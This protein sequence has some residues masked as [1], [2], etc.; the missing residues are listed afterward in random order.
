MAEKR[1]RI[2]MISMFRNEARVMRRM[3][4]SC[5]PHIDY[6]VLQ[7]NGSTDGTDEIVREFFRENPIPGHLYVVEEGWKGFGWNRDHLIQT[8]QGL[9]HGCDWILKMDCDECLEV[10]PDF[11]WSVLDDISTQAWNVVSVGGG[12]M[13]YRMWLWNARLPWR[14]NHDPCHETIRCELSDIDH[15][16]RARDLPLGFRHRGYNEGQSWS[17]PCKFVTDSLILEE[18]LIREGQLPSNMYHFFYLAKSYFDAFRSESLALGMPHQ[19]EYARRAIFYFTEW[20]NRQI[21][22]GR[23]RIDEMVYMAMMMM[24]ESFE[25]FE[26]YDMALDIYRR[27][28][29]FAPGRNDH[30]MGQAEIFKKRRQW[31]EML[32]ITTEMMKPERVNPFPCYAMFINQYMYHDVPDNRVIPLHQTAVE[33]A[34]TGIQHRFDYRRTQSQSTQPVIQPARPLTLRA[35]ARQRMWIVDDFYDDPDAVREYAL[36]LEFRADIRWYKGRRT[37][38]VYRPGELRERFEK[39][40]GRTITNWDVP[41]FNGCFQVTTADDPQVYHYDTQTWAAMIYLTP[42]APLTSGT[43]LHRD[44]NH[45]IRHR[46]DPDPD[47]AFQGGFY[48][49]TR[50]DTVDRAGNVYNRLVIMDAQHIHSAGDYFG[51]D[52][53]TGRLVHLFFFD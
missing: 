42:R 1:T 33:Q 46:T 41:G 4:E 16:I 44:K 11:D 23:P 35:D 49:S 51:T 37:A 53:E 26:D 19:R 5:A 30:L 50:F 20:I 18:K 38:T 14:F 40:M 13:Y 2:V 34:A 25:H 47:R 15:A 3:L 48:D 29:P 52:L 7:D 43:R 36:G 31:D 6:W 27:A 9:D 28:E 8:C 24:A 10:D 32:E 39:I 17:N 45:G 21:S 22:D 12:C